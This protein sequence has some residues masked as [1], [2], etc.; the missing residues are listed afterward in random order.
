M[1]KHVA[2]L[3]LFASVPAIA[4]VEICAGRPN[5]IEP[6]MRIR[7]SQLT[8]ERVQ[9]ALHFLKLHGDTDKDDEYH[10]GRKNSKRTLRGYELKLAA[11]KGGTMEIDAFCQWLAKEGFWYD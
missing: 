3:L 7:E 5:P 10:F 1:M 6:D 11:L 9:S 2:V 4:E 8:P